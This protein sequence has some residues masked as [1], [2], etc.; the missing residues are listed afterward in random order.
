MKLQIKK[1]KKRGKNEEKKRVEFVFALKR[2]ALSQYWSQSGGPWMSHF[3]HSFIA[4]Y[5]AKKEEKKRKKKTGVQI[6]HVK[7][8]NSVSTPLI[9]SDFFFF[10]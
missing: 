3:P 8:K 7:K 9:D 6:V 10:L 4:V 1:N 5:I 2:P